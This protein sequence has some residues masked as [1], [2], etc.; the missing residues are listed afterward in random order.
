MN[1]SGAR[2]G[3]T[4]GVRELESVG[5]MVG[6]ATWQLVSVTGRVQADHRDRE[7]IQRV[8]LQPFK[9]ISRRR[10]LQ[11]VSCTH[12]LAG[13]LLLSCPG[14]GRSGAMFEEVNLNEVLGR[15]EGKV[16]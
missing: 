6:G 4:R 15:I 9:R 5:R 2:E 13:S 16:L 14:R 12:G 7:R 8:L 1:V 3:R 11:S 10:P